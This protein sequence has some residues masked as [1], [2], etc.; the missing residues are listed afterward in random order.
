MQASIPAA[1]AHDAGQGCTALHDCTG[2]RRTTSST[3][4]S[5]TSGPSSSSSLP[6]VQP[7][8]HAAP[9]SPPPSPYSS[10]PPPSRSLRASPL[11]AWP[12]HLGAARAPAADPAAHAVPAA[13]PAASPQAPAL[14]ALPDTGPAPSPQ[15]LL[16]QPPWPVGPGAPPEAG[17]APLSAPQ[18]QSPGSPGALSPQPVASAPGPAPSAPPGA[19]HSCRPPPASLSRSRASRAEGEAAASARL[20]LA[21][22]RLAARAP[23]PLA[24]AAAGGAAGSAAGGLPSA[25]QR[26]P[27][28]AV[29]GFQTG[30]PPSA[31]STLSS[32][33]SRLRG[34]PVPAPGPRVRKHRAQSLPVSLLLCSAQQSV[35]TSSTAPSRHAPALHLYCA[36]ARPA[37]LRAARRCECLACLGA[38]GRPT[39]S[40]CLL[41]PADA[42][43]GLWH[44][45][46]LSALTVLQAK[47]ITTTGKL[48]L[49]HQGWE[50]EVLSKTQG[51]GKARDG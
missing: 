19:P 38:A 3:S 25:F 8:R 32:R 48:R 26:S 13:R 36:A 41:K 30:S 47:R 49:R 4:I 14:S 22:S 21:L 31:G 45:S 12:P 29:Q 44:A 50:K 51:L 27:A 11:P 10:P 1:P 23:W 18:P 46:L 37:R 33:P 42:V 28:G 2:L 15:A 7:P 43:H 24:P 39:D 9:S 35:S 17:P 34:A 5:A 6:A 40:L 20:P 16:R